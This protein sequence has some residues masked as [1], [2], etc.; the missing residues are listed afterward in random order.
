MILFYLI[1]SYDSSYDVVKE[2]SSLS[3]TLASDVKKRNPFNP[4]YVFLTYSEIT[5][6]NDIRVRIAYRMRVVVELR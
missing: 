1:T 6:S 4:S 2:L 3:I 5:R